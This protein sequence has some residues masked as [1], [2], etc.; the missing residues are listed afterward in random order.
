[1]EEDRN[2]G[3]WERHRLCIGASSI[4]PGAD[5]SPLFVA[6][7]GQD[8]NQEIYIVAIERDPMDAVASG[9]LYQITDPTL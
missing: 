1:M 7:L 3:E 8:S 2:T 5:V 4:C 9:V 6:S